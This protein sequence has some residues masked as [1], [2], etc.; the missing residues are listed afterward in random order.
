MRIC[1]VKSIFQSTFN[2]YSSSYENQQPRHLT[3]HFKQMLERKA[4]SDLI[5]ITADRVFFNAI[6]IC[7][8]IPVTVSFLP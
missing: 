7:P 6:S 5:Y 3:A 1:L 4:K 8:R 2:I